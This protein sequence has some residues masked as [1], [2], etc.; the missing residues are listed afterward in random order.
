MNAGFAQAGPKSERI[1]PALSTSGPLVQPVAPR[2]ARGAVARPARR[3]SRLIIPSPRRAPVAGI[4]RRDGHALGG[5]ACQ[6]HTG[7]TPGTRTICDS[8]PLTTNTHN[9]L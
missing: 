4:P 5:R 2:I 9:V 1:S 8:G 7:G 6:G 3:M